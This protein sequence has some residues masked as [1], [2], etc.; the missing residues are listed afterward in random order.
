MHQ[1]DH[2]GDRHQHH[3]GAIVGAAPF[4]TLP[5]FGFFAEFGRPRVIC[6]A[7]GYIVIVGFRHTFSPFHSTRSL[8]NDKRRP[9]YE[10]VGAFANN[11][12]MK[13]SFTVS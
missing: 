5:R 13:Y 3:P 7:V 1:V 11:L 2:I 12:R 9:I 4:R 6:F 8:K 10:M